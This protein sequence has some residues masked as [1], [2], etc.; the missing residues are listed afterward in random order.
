MEKKKLAEAP[1][2][3]PDLLRGD[4]DIAHSRV[5]RVANPSTQYEVQTALSNPIERLRTMGIPVRV[6]EDVKDIPWSKPGSTPLPGVRG[7]FENNTVWL[8]ANQIERG[9]EMTVLAHEVA[10]AGASILFPKA[11]IKELVALIGKLAKDR[12]PRVTRVLA[13]LK[14]VYVDTTGKYVLTPEQEAREVLAHIAEEHPSLV[15]DNAFVR[16][17][18]KLKIE[19]HTW[20]AAW[21]FGGRLDDAMIDSMIAKASKLGKNGFLEAIRAKLMAGT[22]SPEHLRAIEN[23]GHGMGDIF[24]DQQRAEHVL[25]D[26]LNSPFW[27]FEKLGVENP[28]ALEKN[29][30]GKFMTQVQRDPNALPVE[31]RRI[32]KLIE[33]L[34]SKALL[35]LQDAG[36]G[37]ESFREHYFPQMWKEKDAATA[38]LSKRPLKGNEGFRKERVYQDT[39][40]GIKAGLTPISNNPIEL[41][42]MKL[43]EIYKA[44]AM[45][46][47]I[48]RWR[49]QGDV[50]YV[51]MGKTPPTG[52]VKLPDRYGDV[53]HR[54]KSGERVLGGQYFAKKPVADV[55]ENYTSKSLYGSQTV[56]G[57]FRGWMAMNNRMNSV[58]LGAGSL[59]HL[60]F[61]TG[62]SVT[63]AAANVLQDAYRLVTG[64]GSIEHLFD[65]ISHTATSPFAFLYRAKEIME[66]YRKF[67]VGNKSEG[68]TR[69]R[70][71]INDD[72]TKNTP[73][74]NTVK[75]LELGG[76]KLFADH[77][78]ISDD[79][80]K[81]KRAWY[82][83]RKLEAAAR[84]P[85]AILEASAY[86]I[87]HFVVPRQKLIIMDQLVHRILRDNPGKTL[88][89]LT[90]EF[91]QAVNRVDSRLGQ[92]GY[93]RLSTNRMMKELAQ[94]VTRA[95]GWTGGTIAEIGGAVV[96]LGKFF[97]EILRTGKMPEQLPDRLAYTMTLFALWMTINGVLTSYNTGESPTGMDFFAYRTGDKDL[98]GRPIRFLNPT[99]LRDVF[100]WSTAPL[101]TFES[102]ASP[103]LSATLNIAHNTDY[104]GTRIRNEDDPAWMQAAD[105]VKFISGALLPFWL[106]NM[107]K[108]SENT[109]GFWNTA[110][111]HPGKL[112]SQMIGFTVAP[113][114]YTASPAEKEGDRLMK[115]NQKIAGRTAHET[116][117]A[118]EK[119]KMRHDIQG[120]KLSIPDATRQYIRDIGLSGL[121]TFVKTIHSTTL[122]RELT[123]VGAE[124]ALKIWR[125]ADQKERKDLRAIMFRKKLSVYRMSKDE[126]DR[127][128]PL[129]EEALR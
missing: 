38:Y 95:P 40:E 51:P 128:L 36:I 70:S 91:R 55:V 27:Y 39:E 86:P 78:L 62:E 75:A 96:D 99:Y 89:E 37:L 103:M 105:V 5:S 129:Y 100:S 72:P 2:Q 119:A 10:H 45:Q 123:T 12:N 23:L 118:K 122:Q 117:I 49:E 80:E 46:R 115:E 7:A 84:S 56:G 57:L 69:R 125:K 15:H 94:A 44:A 53:W 30:G 9:Q 42:Q 76:G 113:K 47:A 127:L 68:T 92:V 74:Q 104:F 14:K 20:M 24:H 126:R 82:G 98:D 112:V 120:G 124:D 1:I 108:A 19:V 73:A 121:G 35:D 81:F 93:D 63:S 50:E 48:N 79:I 85:L 6:V 106:T 83:D 3:L 65:S 111:T 66:E 21:G 64:K 17:Y 107:Q 114:A 59:F 90:P 61:T 29:P 41:A 11:R 110:A 71:D 33:T 8:V 4:E 88:H 60:G 52:S 109:G 16:F 58:Q 116:A 22:A 31:Q 77:Y 97:H 32:A 87:V 25:R 18:T 28:G 102:K 67:D 34:F 54:T 13:D 101:D 43:N 26:G